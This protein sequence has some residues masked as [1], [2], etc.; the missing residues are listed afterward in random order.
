ML[1]WTCDTLLSEPYAPH[2]AS[3]INYVLGKDKKKITSQFV[4]GAIRG[5]NALSRKITFY[6]KKITL[7]PKR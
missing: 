6:Q 3:C 5:D 2:A 1:N 7:Y 4:D